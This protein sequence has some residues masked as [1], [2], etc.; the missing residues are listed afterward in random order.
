MVSKPK[1]QMAK[2]GTHQKGPGPAGTQRPSGDVFRRADTRGRAATQRAGTET[3]EVAQELG[4]TTEEV[5][6]KGSAR[7]LGYAAQRM[8]VATG[9]Q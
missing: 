2:E 6:G 7:G 3:K 9:Q 5:G 8:G 1:G 4:K